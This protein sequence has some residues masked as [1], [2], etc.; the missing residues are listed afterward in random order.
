[1]IRPMFD[2]PALKGIVRNICTTVTIIGLCLF[3][4]VCLDAYEGTLA[5]K[6]FSSS[7]IVAEHHTYALLLSLPVPLHIIFI[8]LI[9]QKRWLSDG[10]ARFA[11][12]GIVGSGLWLGAALVVKMFLL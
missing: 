1:M 6:Y 12:F 7:Q 11:W 10:L 9:V 3:G 2:S 4:L 8:G 5:A